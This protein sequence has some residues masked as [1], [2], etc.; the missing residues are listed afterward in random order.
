MNTEQHDF[1]DEDIDSDEAFDSDDEKKY[2]WAFQKD[3][4]S[5]PPKR[6]PLEDEQ[7]DEE[8]DDD[9]YDGVVS[10][11]DLINKRESKKSKEIQS[12]KNDDGTNEESDYLDEDPNLGNH[13]ELLKH[14]ERI[15]NSERKKRKSSDSS[16]GGGSSSSSSSFSTGELTADDLLSSLRNSSGVAKLKKRAEKLED[17][18]T[19]SAPKARIHRKRAE[20][21]VGYISAKK[22]ATDWTALVS[23][24]RQAEHVEYTSAGTNRAPVTTSDM[25]EKFKP[26]TDMEQQID[27]L[28]T[29]SGM[30]ES[31]LKNTEEREL[32]LNELT[33]EEVSILTVT[34][35]KTVITM[36]MF[37]CFFCV[38]FPMIDKTM[39]IQNVA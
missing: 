31:S 20:R 11:L 32:Q 12:N 1:D 18:S 2:G 33:E 14:M 22:N 3:E 13:D 7:D 6:H 35:I 21:Q 34:T 9:D 37:V 4:P 38:I 8:E 29:S 25:V 10:V 28:L 39:L 27:A 30:D 26:T 36:A 23:K 5:T 19:T 16:S 17:G 24:N 15:A